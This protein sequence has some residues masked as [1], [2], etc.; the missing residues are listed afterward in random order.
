MSIQLFD[1]VVKAEEILGEIGVDKV[2]ISILKE[3]A[4]FRTV[5]LKDVSL[6]AAI[7]IKQTFLSKGA[8]AATKREVASLKAEKTDMLLMGTLKQYRMVITSLRGQPFGL[9]KISIDLEKL[10]FEKQN[11]DLI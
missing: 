4:V 1:D 8:D 9:K 11:A 10:L 7:I 2:G 5:L 3:K 6:K